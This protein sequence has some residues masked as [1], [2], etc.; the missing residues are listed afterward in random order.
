M[1]LTRDRAVPTISASVLGEAS[2]QAPVT[3]SCAR[4]DAASIHSRCAIYK[5]PSGRAYPEN[6]VGHSRAA[7]K[8]VIRRSTDRGSRDVNSKPQLLRLTL[9]LLRDGLMSARSNA[10][11]L[12]PHPWSVIHRRAGD[13]GQHLVNVSR[14]Y[15][16]S[17]TS[18]PSSIRYG[19]S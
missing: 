6:S 12:V 11:S 5:H 18:P 15:Q 7:H 1:K 14:Q 17:S 8:H 10:H 19:I 3:R 9:L 16:V 4:Y 2:V 13:A